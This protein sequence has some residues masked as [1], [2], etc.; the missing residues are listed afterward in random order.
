MVNNGILPHIFHFVYNNSVKLV[1]LVNRY[2]IPENLFVTMFVSGIFALLILFYPKS[3]NQELESHENESAF[4]PERSV[5]WVRALSI[6][7]FI[8]PTL[9]LY[10]YQM[11]K[12]R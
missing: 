3:K 11:I 5:L 1:D 4:L 10:F 12:L 9:A 6:F 8:A 7:V 2:G